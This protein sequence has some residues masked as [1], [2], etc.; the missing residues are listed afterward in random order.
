DR[1]LQ[2]VGGNE[3]IGVDVR[4]IAATHRDLRSFVRQG[5]FRADLYYRLNVVHIEMPPLRERAGDV[6]LLAQLF[7]SRFAQQNEKV[8]RGFTGEAWNRI[9]NYPWPGNVR[10]LENAIEGAVVLCD[11]DHVA[12]RHLP[13]H[14]SSLVE[15]GRSGLKIPGT[16][17]ASME[18]YL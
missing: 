15:S 11:G 6:A 7:L 17:L 5:L 10:E 3:T 18:R 1:E 4:I 2:R 9:L 8:I 16:S 12:L 13:V 14:D